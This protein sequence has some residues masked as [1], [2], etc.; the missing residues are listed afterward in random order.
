AVAANVP[1]AQG[2]AGESQEG[3]LLSVP[4]RDGGN[5]VIGGAATQA[6]NLV[7]KENGTQ[8][9]ENSK[10]S[11]AADG[12]VQGDAGTVAL[13][14]TAAWGNGNSSN[15]ALLT[16]G[17]SDPSGNGME[18]VKNATGLVL[19]VHDGSGEAQYVRFPLE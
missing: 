5:P 3:V 14:V 10:L 18:L 9:S 15:Q 16:I 7:P 17:S 11:Y 13:D 6:D 12:H 19:M 4:F 1:D 8:F 2:A